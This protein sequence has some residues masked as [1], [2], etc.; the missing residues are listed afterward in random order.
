MLSYKRYIVIS[1]KVILPYFLR[2][3]FMKGGFVSKIL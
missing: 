2:N 1:Y 3:K